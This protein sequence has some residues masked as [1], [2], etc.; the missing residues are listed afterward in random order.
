MKI[1]D[2]FQRSALTRVLLRFRR[3]FLVVG[4]FSLVANLLML[5]PTIYMLQIYDRAMVSQSQM[6]LL[7]VSLVAIFFFVVMAFSEWMRSKLL[8]KAGIR[9]DEILNA[10]VFN[11]SFESYLNRSGR[12][13]SESFADL[14]H[15]RQFLTGNGIFAFFDL[16][17]TPI[18]I[19]VAWLLHPWIGFLSLLFVLVSAW[20]A[21]V[22]HR[23][24]HQQTTAALQSH[25]KTG[26]FVL[27]KLRNSEVIE[28]MGML[29]QLRQ[30]W[31]ELRRQA[32][33]DHEV[34]TD[35]GHRV[36]AVIKF[37]RYAQQSLMLAAGAILVIRGEMTPGSMIAAN[38]LL[39]RALQPVELLVG[40]WK[41]FLA[42]ALSFNRLEEL[43]EKYPE[44]SPCELP[45][46]PRGE[47]CLD[48][49]V[50]RAAGRTAPILDGLNA[51]FPAG[52]VN[53]I[54]G[55]S[56]SGKST[57]ARCL[58]GIW[59]ETEGL[60][61]L[62]GLPLTRW[63][64]SE[65]G[66]HVGYLPQDVELLEGTVAENIARFGAVDPGKVIEAAKQAGVHEMVLRFPKGYDTPMGEGGQLLSAGQRQRIALARAL[67]RS[68]V[69]IVLDEPNSNLDDAGE[70]A[71]IKVLHQ[72][73]EQKRSVFLIS[74]RFL[75]LDVIDCVLVLVDGQIR[76]QGTRQEIFNS[77][78]AKPSP[79]GVF[80][81]GVPESA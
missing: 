29:G 35:W 64:R 68:P 14:S 71:L 30:R 17:W 47:I 55:P 13:P 74:H 72:L 32:L 53:L 16:P 9:F 70:A 4:I 66:R 22:G 60:V 15:I 49:L 3:E 45:A 77:P 65:L 48:N 1:P 67:Y 23:L 63:E 28:S 10:R 44:K 43:L 52:Q 24:T 33:R 57:L 20:V 12:N 31:D 62:D 8:I 56:G 11:A 19:F 39:S 79:A 46:E 2:F 36:Q 40:N 26:T 18:Y 5:T 42:A 41:N 61:L 73:S 54:I 6:T 75:A 34:S 21:W 7:A 59:P 80:S 37:V 69:L 38:V 76:Q 58:L 51:R 81:P 25:Q 27:E 50:A 78:S